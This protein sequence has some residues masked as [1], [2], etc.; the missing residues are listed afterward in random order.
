MLPD[1][2]P[3]PPPNPKK[4]IVPKRE[5]PN[6]YPCQGLREGELPD[7]MSEEEFANLAVAD[8]EKIRKLA[9][10]FRH[11]TGAHPS[12]AVNPA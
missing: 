2:H 1:P 12:H 11:R 3:G 9:M 8:V 5:T 7:G 6:T 10:K 4:S